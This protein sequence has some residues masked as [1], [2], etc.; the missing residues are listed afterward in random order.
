MRVSGQLQ[1]YAE[2]SGLSRRSRLIK[3]QTRPNR[4]SARVEK[5]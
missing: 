3:S 5:H 4:M 1:R 2:F